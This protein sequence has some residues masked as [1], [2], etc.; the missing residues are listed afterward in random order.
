MAACE[1]YRWDTATSSE[2]IMEKLKA[3]FNDEAFA[4]D[5]EGLLAIPEI[6]FFAFDTELTSSATIA[7]VGSEPL[8]PR[9]GSIHGLLS[10]SY[11]G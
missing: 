2:E 7:Y 5:I 6:D 4:S 11:D 3:T 1:L 8:E 9:S 10:K